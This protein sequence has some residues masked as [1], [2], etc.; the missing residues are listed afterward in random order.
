MYLK[1]VLFI[2][3]TVVFF[4]KCSDNT[5]SIEGDSEHLADVSIQKC[6]NNAQCQSGYVCDPV[7]KVCVPAR[8]DGG[9]MCKNNLD[10][11]E[12]D[13]E[14]INGRCVKVVDV[15]TND[16][17]SDVEPSDI[18]FYC[19]EDRDCKDPNKVCD[20]NTHQCIDKNR[21]ILFVDPQVI[22]F[23]AVF[24]G[25]CSKRIFKIQNMGSADLRITMIDFESGTN[26]EPPDTPRFTLN[27]PIPI[28]GTISAGSSIDI[29]V[30]YCQDDAS[31]DKGNILIISNDESKPQYKLPIVSSYKDTP[32]FAI[33][34]EKDFNKRLWPPTANPY[35][36]TIDMGN[37]ESGKEIKKRIY[38]TNVAN[39]AIL[40]IS[41]L[42]LTKTSASNNTFDMKIFNN[43]DPQNAVSTPIYDNPSEVYYIEITFKCNEDKFDEASVITFNT[44][45]PDID[46]VGNNSTPDDGMTTV[47]IK[48]QCNYQGPKLTLDKQRIDFGTV[49][50][51]DEK[52]EQIV[53]KND[54]KVNLVITEAFID[55]PGSSLS[56]LVNNQ[57]VQTPINITPGGSTTFT[58][59]YAPKSIETISTKLFIKSNDSLGNDNISIPI[60]ANAI[61]PT[62]SV[63]NTN[64]DFGIV[65]YDSA[66]SCSSEVKMINISNAGYGPLIINS[67]DLTVGSSSDFILSN[68]P[69]MPLTLDSAQKFAISVSFVPSVGSQQNGQPTQRTGAISIKNSDRKSNFEVV[70]PLVGY[71]KTC[72]PFRNN[73]IGNCTCQT[74]CAYSC[75][76]DFYDLNGDLNSP[77]NSDG[78]EYNCVKTQDPKEICDGKDNDCNGLT[79]DGNINVLCP[80]PPNATAECYQGS[81]KIS[82]CSSGY[83]DVDGLFTNGC[84][85]RADINDLQGVG[86]TCV[87][88]VAIQGEF[89]DSS[90][91][92]LDIVGNIIPFNDEDWF[93]VVARDDVNADRNNGGDNFNFSVSFIDNPDNAYFLEIR[94][95]DCSN[96][97]VKCVNDT[98]FQWRTNFRADVVPG[99]YYEGE[100]PCTPNCQSNNYTTN[101]CNDNSRVYYIRIYR[102]PNAPYKCNNYIIRISNGL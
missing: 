39:E 24:F 62:I 27:I 49:Q 22:N 95:A 58:I 99:G 47:L 94:E 68:I 96:A 100:N 12:P 101:C 16:S 60:I 70:I 87:G 75:M 61:D 76:Q 25:Q 93:R 98:I 82:S 45:D 91:N 71:G 88:A 92:I 2:L 9:E 48:A 14:C 69:N 65:L 73:A 54:G 28:P 52:T 32:D 19:D 20:L 57:P 55:N 51:N 35:Q 79:D 41:K 26:P 18:S 10:C 7:K 81:C 89:V 15:I 50:V 85:C 5:P 23:G 56:L 64:V 63:D 1:I 80:I 13:T 6:T 36:Y 34:D 44:N 102:N 90:K 78:C 53:A 38:F 40:E 4:T 67:I 3:I 97:N 46:T 66:Q 86:N 33:I 74:G 11:N 37:A 72:C 43:I 84:E 29:E 83:Y 77:D 8:P 42:Y 30:Q 59:K 31:P 21:P 17:G